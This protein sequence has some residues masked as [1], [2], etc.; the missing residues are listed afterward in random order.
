MKA[1][2]CLAALASAALA[3]GFIG[4]VALAAQQAAEQP[5]ARAYVRVD[6][7]TAYAK[8]Q[9]KREYR[10]VMPKGAD[11]TWLGPVTSGATHAGSFTKKGLI[12]GWTRLGYASKPAEAT[13]MWGRV[14]N[15]PPE[16]RTA[17]VS[18]PRINADGQLTFVA[19]VK[20]T[21]PAEMSD[22]SIN[23]APGSDGRQS[24][25]PVQL[26][27]WYIDNTTAYVNVKATG[28]SDATVH[29]SCSSTRPDIALSKSTSVLAVNLQGFACGDITVNGHTP[30]GDYS[31]VWLSYPSHQ[32]GEMSSVGVDVGV[33]AANGSQFEWAYTIGSWGKNGASPSPTTDQHP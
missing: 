8:K 11:V 21:L 19:K 14:G 5:A 16:T 4:P 29:W 7:G 20:G 15:R 10:I 25:Y 12:A 23:L 27:S 3:L 9:A 33:T 24:R 2:L 26:G 17:T 31:A 6:G 22:F 32:N 13:L 30:D 28:D 1:R 18:K